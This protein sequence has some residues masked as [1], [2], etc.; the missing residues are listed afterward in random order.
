MI[1]LEANSAFTSY[2][3][4][5][6]ANPVS[7]IQLDVEVVSSPTLSYTYLGTR[8]PTVYSV[9]VTNTGPDATAGMLVEPRIRIESPLDTPVADE[10]VGNQRPLPAPSI[11]Q[12]TCVTWERIRLPAHPAVLGRLAEKINASLVVDLLDDSGNVIWAE[13][14]PLT[15]LAANEWVLDDTH[16]GSLAAFVMPNSRAIQPILQRARE[17]LEQATGDPSTDGYQSGLERA[18]EIAQEVYEAI[19]DQSINYSNP[20]TAFEVA[21]QKVRTPAMVLDG[22]EATCLDSSVLYA[23]CLAA[24]GLDPVLFIVEGHAFSG[25]FTKGPLAAPSVIDDKGVIANLYLQEGGP[26]VQPVETT[27]MCSSPISRDFRVACT[28]NDKYWSHASNEMQCLLVPRVA[29]AEGYTAPPS[30]DALLADEQDESTDGLTPGQRPATPTIDI[31]MPE[32]VAVKVD[33]G[34]DRQT[35]PRVRQWQNSLLDLSA[36]NQLLKMKANSPRFME[37]EVPPDLL[38][39]IDDDLFTPDNRLAILT[40]GDLPDKWR[41]NGVAKEEF[42]A[43]V[44]AQSSPLVFPPYS[45]IN[46]LPKAVQDRINDPEVNRPS[47]DIERRIHLDFEEHCRKQ[48]ANR[49]TKIRSRAREVHLESGTN[50]T[51]LAMGVVTWQQTTSYQGKTSQTRWEAPLYLYP[52]IIDGNRSSGFSIRLDPSGTITPNHCLRE[53]LRREPYN[54]DLPELEYPETDEFGIDFD[55]MIGSIDAKLHDQKLANFS[56]L[57]RCILGVFDYSTFRLWKDLKDDWE[58]IRD[59]NPVVRHLMYTPGQDYTHEPVVPEPHLEPYLPL[60]GDDSQTE[61]IQWALDGRS[62]RLEGPPGTGKT[63]TI[64]NLIASCLAHEKKILFVAE[65]FTALEQVKKRLVDIGLGDYCLELHANGDTDPRIRRNIQQQ[66][67]EA[68]DARSDPKDRQW[69]DLAAR[70]VADE[71]TLDHYRDALHE[72]GSAERSLWTAREELLA[73]GD[74]DTIDIPRAFLD[75]HSRN[76]PEF[77]NTIFELTDRVEAAVSL[78]GNP[79]TLVDSATDSLDKAAL[80]DVM[81]RL[82]SILDEFT[83]ITGP[84]S[85][86]HGVTSIAGLDA[87][88]L[89]ARLAGDGSLPSSAGLAMVGGPTWNRI[90]EEA[91]AQTESIGHRL[92][93]ARQALRPFTLDRPDLAELAGLATAVTSAGLFSRGKRRKAL[94]AALGDD[95]ITTD[96]N[97]LATAVLAVHAEAAVTHELADRLTEE[98]RLA[99]PDG[100]NPMTD[101]ASA[102]L[103]DLIHGTRA[104]ATHCDSPGVGDFIAQLTTEPSPD[105]LAGAVV[106]QVI[107]SWQDL[108]RLLILTDT[109]FERWLKGRTLLEAWAAT[110]PRWATDRGERD[111]YLELDRWMAIIGEADRFIDCGLPTLR[112]PVLAGTLPLDDL[113]LRAL[114]G[115]LRATFDERLEAGEIDNFDGLR[116][117]QRIRRLERSMTDARS[118]MVDRIP[119]LVSERKKQPKV[120]LKRPVGEAHDL[121]RGLKAKRGDKVPI[122]N[123][124]QQFGEALSDVMPCFLMSPDSVA[125]LVPVGSIPFDVVIFDEASQVRTSHAIGALGRGAAN[126]VV[127]DSKQMPPTRFFSSNLGRFVEADSDEADI[128]DTEFDDEGADGEGGFLPIAAAAADLESILQEFEETRIPDLQLKVHYRSRDESLIAFSNSHIYDEPMLTFPSSTGGTRALQFRPIP[129]QF[130]R[131]GTDPNLLD[132]HHQEKYL[133]ANTVLGGQ[134]RNVVGTNP[135]E[136]I[137]MVDEIMNRLR[138]PER[139]RSRHAG[140]GNGAESMIAVTLNVAQR[141]LVEA[142]LEF[143]DASGDENVLEAALNGTKNED[144]G[145]IT[146]EPQLKIRNLEA[147]QGDEADTVMLSI[148]FSKLGPGERGAGT[149]NVPMNFG[150]VTRPGGHRRLNVAVT[151]ARAETIVFCSFD[152]NDMNVK[153]TSSEEAQ[154]LHQF[155]KLAHDGVERHGG[156][157]IIVKRSHHINDIATAIEDRGYRVGTQIG[158]SELRV[159]I[160]IGRPDET[161]WR[162]AVMIDGLDW[163]K[164]GSAAQ[165]EILPKAVLETRGWSRVLRVWLPSWRDERDAVLTRIC[166]AMEGI[167]EPVDDPIIEEPV[168]DPIIEEPVDD[169]II[170]EPVDDPAD[171]DPDDDSHGVHDLGEFQAFEPNVVYEEGHLVLDVLAKPHLWDQASCERAQRLLMQVM[172]EV[173]AVEAP[174]EATRLAKYVCTVLGFERILKPRVEV[175]KAC[176][177]EENV[178]RSKFGDFVWATPNQ[179]DTWTSWRHSS[180]RIR[181]PEEIAPQEYCNALRYIIAD[182]GSLAPDDCKEALRFQFGFKTK[183]PKL[184]AHIDAIFDHAVATGVVAI[185]DDGRVSIPDTV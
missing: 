33:D 60:P 34:E 121:L 2:S 75:D 52:V 185:S 128:D 14:R 164:R 94:T 9:S 95:A 93:T 24:A 64:A 46:Q 172:S 130:I 115:V 118:L 97:A 90:A 36:R 56:V 54:M 17:R 18:R 152:P 102:N 49:V 8:R 171:D 182:L 5:G 83:A 30:T 135:D 6:A 42:D 27:T 180:D 26:L 23:S 114:R 144:T 65:K 151:R 140:A 28:A 150:P 138:D 100:W 167:E 22:K 168:D 88:V 16:P 177:P 20:G 29:W 72:P 158:L 73:I 38:G 51:H 132:E 125:A 78:I 91:I 161:D 113:E 32:S 133:L 13:R 162:V 156:I 157:G 70:M 108:G 62:F 159:D 89:A 19:R 117:D 57:R 175:V 124:I 179:A 63:Q 74:G 85:T 76:W 21:V 50:A 137:A 11:D 84:W 106:E 68:I 173:L 116:H 123:L 87:A 110:Q 131:P 184:N 104:L 1:A 134:M 170:E 129:G 147:V 47:F 99:I 109:G 163:A 82:T 143:A 25:Y 181:Q 126:I 79:W 155:L 39:R 53:K 55:A 146:A 15:L 183:S 148:A 160:A 96:G 119:G 86:L 12:P 44:R 105:R 101:D 111:R 3:T 136:A 166:D 141:K 45:L 153:P 59:A 120:K 176:L 103:A 58:K 122:R 40:P 66:L 145:A 10:W 112:N 41:Y 4:S 80:S 48:I 67:G 149:N 71:R 61:A 37:F 139:Q 98:L 178:T 92:M 142:L 107:D 31:S 165:R 154:L 81:D 7:E 43:F 174:I 127:G 69:R 169:P 77:Q 35:P